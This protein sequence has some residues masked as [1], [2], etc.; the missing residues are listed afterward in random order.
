MKGKKKSEK[1]KKKKVGRTYYDEIAR[2]K[3]VFT[4]EDNYTT[5]I[6]SNYTRYRRGD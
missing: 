6:F 1:E 5:I 3:N 4:A 2:G